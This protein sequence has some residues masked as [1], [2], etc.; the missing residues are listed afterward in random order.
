MLSACT[1]VK[2]CHPDLVY[3]LTC[4]HNRKGNTYDSTALESWMAPQATYGVSDKEM[5]Q[6]LLSMVFLQ[7]YTYNN[8]VNLKTIYHVSQ[9]LHVSMHVVYTLN[10]THV[11]C[12]CVCVHVCVCVCAHVCCCTIVKLSALPLYVEDGEQ[13]KC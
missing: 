4:T 12:V 9:S 5:T 11:I 6:T 8:N 3:K 7:P 10:Y 13:Y 2:R 1:W